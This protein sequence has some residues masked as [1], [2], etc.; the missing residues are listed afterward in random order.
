M[1]LTEDMRLAGRVLAGD[2]DAFAQIVRDNQ[3]RVRAYLGRHIRGSAMVD[4]L[5]QDV[6]VSAYKSLATYSGEAPLGAW[7]MGITR[8]RALMHLRQLA[9]HAE[10]RAE[11]LDDSLAGWQLV[12]CEAEGDR[13]LRMEE[14]M[15]ALKGCIE[16]LAG[17]NRQAVQ[18]HYYRGKDTETIARSLNMKGT[19]LRVMLMRIRDSLRKC[20]ET[21][22]QAETA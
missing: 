7:L 1:N 21:T 3:G 15:E 16:S 19:A 2:D 18:A 4:D 13:D 22:L 14:Q 9:R 6:F 12:A 8:H 5:A 20:I 17:R 10:Q 11:S